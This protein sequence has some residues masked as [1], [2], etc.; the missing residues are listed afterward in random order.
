M[1]KILSV[2]MAA[3]VLLP[4]LPRPAQSQPMA[5]EL[6]GSAPGCFDDAVRGLEPGRRVTVHRAGQEPVTGLFDSLNPDSTR[7]V[8]R[9]PA[10]EHAQVFECPLREIRALEYHE[11]GHLNAGWILAGLVMGVAVGAAAAALVSDSHHDEGFLDFGTM[12][13]EIGCVAGGAGVGLMLGTGIP[14]SGHNRR[15]ECEE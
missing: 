10:E 5:A 7:I 9:V 4:T 12:G 13:L 11:K 1:R 14:L 6:A 2:L 15:V 8:M 3:L